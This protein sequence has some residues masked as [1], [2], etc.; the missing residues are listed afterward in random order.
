MSSSTSRPICS[1]NPIVWREMKASPMSAITA[2]LMVSLLLIT[3]PIFGT[4]PRSANRRSIDERVPDPCSRT[5]NVSSASDASGM[6]R[7]A[8]SGCAGGAIT[9]SG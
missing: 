9:T 4:K 7:A 1:S 2:C 5:R 6:R 8:A 3:L